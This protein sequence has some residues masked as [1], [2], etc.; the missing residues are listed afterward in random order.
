[1]MYSTTEKRLTTTWVN[2]I[3]SANLVYTRNTSKRTLYD[4]LFASF[5]LATMRVIRINE[6]MN[7]SVMKRIVA[8]SI[9]CSQIFMSQ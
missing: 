9:T 5:F 2:S 8:R 3:T 4:S 1:M 7:A 6:V